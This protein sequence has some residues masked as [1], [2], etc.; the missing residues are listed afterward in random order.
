MPGTAETI[1]RG[2]ELPVFAR[3]R[4][5]AGRGC[6]LAEAEKKCDPDDNQAA[7]RPAAKVAALWRADLADDHAWQYEFEPHAWGYAAL[8][9]LLVDPGGTGGRLSGAGAEVGLA[10]VARLRAIT[11][12]AACLP[13]T[14][15]ARRVLVGKLS[16]Q[17]EPLLHGRCGAQVH[18]A[19]LAAVAEGTL[20]AG[21]MTLELW[22]R[23]ALAQAYLVQG[24]ALA[25]AGG[26]RPLG[27]AILCAMS[28]QA[29]SVG[30]QDEAR[31]LV[32]TAHG[33]WPGGRGNQDLHQKTNVLNGSGSVRNMRESRPR[34]ARSPRIRPALA[35]SAA[36]MPPR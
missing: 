17:A 1:A 15:R 35:S 8:R 13:D 12:A 10:D 29:A 14:G 30:H 9:W 20:L 4:F 31:H 2:L 28:E 11:G 26:D 25:Q 24:L 27:A 32:R 19:L 21:R 18:Q 5:R 6:V 36:D 7:W 16:A 33:G 23:S 3:R 22:P 34:D